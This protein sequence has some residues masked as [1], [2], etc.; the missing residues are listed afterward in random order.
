[1]VS[2]MA[3]QE[4]MAAGGRRQHHDSDLEESDHNGIGHTHRPRHNSN[5]IG[6]NGNYGRNGKSS[7]SC[8]CH[9][10]DLEESGARGVSC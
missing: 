6:A 7:A 8:E 1:M 10:S 9:D 2:C 4:N 3:L 5:S